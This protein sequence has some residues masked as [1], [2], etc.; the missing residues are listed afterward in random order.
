MA[1]FARTGCHRNCQPGRE[2][3]L[4]NLSLSLNANDVHLYNHPPPSSVRPI[5]ISLKFMSVYV[6]MGDHWIA[7]AFIVAFNCRAFY[8]RYTISSPGAL[9]PGEFPFLRN[10]KGEKTQSQR[11][12]GGRERERYAE[13]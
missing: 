4:L 7:A 11:E 9:R 6:L 12:E 2:T 8:R 5:K 13:R 3:R 1:L 10:A